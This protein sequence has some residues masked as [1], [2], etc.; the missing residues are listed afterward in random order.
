M[1][2]ATRTNSA[3]AKG[4]TPRKISMSLM[5][6]NEQVSSQRIYACQNCIT[7]IPSSLLLSLDC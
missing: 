6:G 5:S 4:I 1:I 2:N 7:Q 3:A